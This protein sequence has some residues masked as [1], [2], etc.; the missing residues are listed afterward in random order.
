[1]AQSATDHTG[2]ATE[3]MHAPTSSHVYI[4]IFVILAIITAIEVATSF[5][6]SNGAIGL[7]K[8]ALLLALSLAKGAL[9]VMYFMHLKF[10]S[11]WFTI[12]FVG[13]TAIA[14]VLMITFLLLFSYHS[15]LG[16][17]NVAG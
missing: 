7:L 17:V 15:R 1:M 6:P 4:R 16:V 9:V 8:V 12:L 3:H 2:T 5:L 10:D 11:R 13:G 14:T